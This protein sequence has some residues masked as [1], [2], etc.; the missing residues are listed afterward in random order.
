MAAIEA[1]FGAAKRFELF[2]GNRSERT[3]C[4]YGRLG[5]R[6]FRRQRITDKFVFVFLEKPEGERGDSIASGG[7]HGKGPDN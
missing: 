2:T 7:I 3:L 1:S 6:A 4:L 5:Y